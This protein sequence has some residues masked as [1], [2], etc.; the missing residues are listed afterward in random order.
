M[1]IT[2]HLAVDSLANLDF[3]STKFFEKFP[4]TGIIFDW[5]PS[6]L[7]QAQ[8]SAGQGWLAWRGRNAAL[9]YE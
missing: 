1:E 8:G 2:L 4:H 3:V 7:Q 5:F 9:K 6:T